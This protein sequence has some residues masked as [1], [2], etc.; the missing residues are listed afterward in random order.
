M[1]GGKAVKDGRRGGHQ[2]A[3]SEAEEDWEEA[4]I[5]RRRLVLDGLGDS[6]PNSSKRFR[7]EG[8]DFRPRAAVAP[9]GRK[10][11]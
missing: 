7:A 9:C 6:P 11:L 10:G 2:S 5:V 4:A 3:R 8:D 1:K